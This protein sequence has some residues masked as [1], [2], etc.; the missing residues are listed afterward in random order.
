MNEKR[1]FL[2]VPK[3]PWSSLLIVLLLALGMQFL[4]FYGI[5]AGPEGILTDVFLQ[6]IPL[7]R[8]GQGAVDDVRI[9]TLE[10]D[11]AA[12][13]SCF[14]N[15]S[16]LDPGILTTIFETL[17]AANAS[18]GPAL[19]GVDIITDSVS[20]QKLQGLA[21]IPKPRFVFAAGADVSNVDRERITDWISGAEH[22]ML[23]QPSGVLGKDDPSQLD[24]AVIWAIPAFPRDEDLRLRRF[25]R[26]IEVALHPGNTPTQF[27]WAK[28]VAKTYCDITNHCTLDPQGEQVLLSFFK[29]AVEDG[30]RFRLQDLFAC[31][32]TPH[33]KA[34]ITILDKPVPQRWPQFRAALTQLPPTILL[35]GG[36]F[37]AGRD[38]YET[39]VG[40][41]PGLLMNAYAIQAEFMH[42]GVDEVPP[43][44]ALLLDILLGFLIVGIFAGRGNSIRSKITWCGAGILAGFLGSA[45]A[46]AWGFLW[47]SCIG[48]A[49]GVVIHLFIE[50]FRESKDWVEKEE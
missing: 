30:N 43:G 9:V 10:I 5:L 1:S 44:W 41:L 50:I 2:A 48:V 21:K 49:V 12:Y 22:P 39:P 11:N 25:P 34:T 15:A 14:R 31:S 40:P 36:T 42:N 4:E 27:S 17:T 7:P 37:S 32:S 16:P 6:Y 13:K 28:A 38:T 29:P 20:D 24:P 35:V 3:H 45:A 18:P 33:G 26:S 47:F 46:F 23:A 19:I 8:R